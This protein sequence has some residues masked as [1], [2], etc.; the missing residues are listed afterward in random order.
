[1]GMASICHVCLEWQR[2]LFYR[3]KTEVD[4]GNKEQEDQEIQRLAKLALG[5]HP[6]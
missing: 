1:M 2:K 6:P 4:Q 5:S 3:E